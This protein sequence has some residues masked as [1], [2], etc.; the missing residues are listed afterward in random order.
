VPRVSVYFAPPY[1]FS[2]LS[3]GTR[4][5]HPLPH[6]RSVAASGLPH[7]Y[8][9]EPAAPASRY[10]RGT[11]AGQRSGVARYILTATGLSR[12]LLALRAGAP[13]LRPF[14]ARTATHSSHRA[15]P[16]AAQAHARLS[17]KLLSARHGCPLP[18]AIPRDA[19]S[20]DSQLSRQPAPCLRRARPGVRRFA[21][22]R[23]FAAWRF[24]RTRPPK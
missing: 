20:V 13:F 19:Q 22:A 1:R 16:S 5:S 15:R 18:S 9:Y 23:T 14:P 2:R 4:F 21:V 10:S 3:R 6:D 12:W 24:A 7:P 17:R 11:A 8:V